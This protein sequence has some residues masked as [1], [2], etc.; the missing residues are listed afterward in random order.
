MTVEG[1]NNPMSSI[2]SHP[3][4]EGKEGKEV[5]V[6]GGRAV[7]CSDNFDKRAS[8]QKKL[9]KKGNCHQSRRRGRRGRSCN[10]LL[11][12]QQR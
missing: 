8:G 11:M 12:E 9:W 10:F 3:A 4:K 6:A 7:E 5:L 1:E 2:P